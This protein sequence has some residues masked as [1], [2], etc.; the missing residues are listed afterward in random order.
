MPWYL[1]TVKRMGRTT[2]FAAIGRRIAPRFDRAVIRLSG[3]R[4]RT[5]ERAAL[6]TLLLTHTGRRS[7]RERTTPLLFDS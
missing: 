4:L 5:S 6:P 2:W 3:G 1:D 7:G